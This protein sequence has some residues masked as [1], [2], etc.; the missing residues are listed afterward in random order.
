[1]YIN[2]HTAVSMHVS[3]SS[4]VHILGQKYIISECRI[5]GVTVTMRALS[6]SASASDIVQRST[7]AVTT[8]DV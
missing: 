4:L 5:T 3:A 7:S 2:Y 8:F 1:M 6:R